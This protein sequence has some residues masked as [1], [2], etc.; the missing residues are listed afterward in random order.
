MIVLNSLKWKNFLSTGNQYNEIELDTSPMSIVVGKNGAGKSSIIDALTYGLFGKSFKKVNTNQ[1]INSVNERDMVV[2]VFF[3]V[4]KRKYHIKRGL[5]PRLFEIYCGGELIDQDA[6]ARDYQKYLE[7]SILKLNYKSFTQIVVLGSALFVPFM[8]LSSSDRRIIIEDIL[9][10][11]VFSVM[12]NLVKEKLSETNVANDSNKQDRNHKSSQIELHEKYINDMSLSQEAIINELKV[13]ASTLD[14]LIEN[15]QKEIKQHE[16]KIAELQFQ[17]KNGGL[18]SKARELDKLDIQIEST[19]QKAVASYSFLKHTKNCP[20]C[21]QDISEEFKKEKLIKKE[22]KIDE[23]KIALLDLTKEKQKIDKDVKFNEDIDQKVSKVNNQVIHLKSEINLHGQSKEDISSKIEDK[24]IKNQNL[25]EEKNLL[26]GLRAKLEELE[27]KRLDISEKLCYYGRINNLLQDGG[28]KTKIIKQY[29]PVINS[30]VNKYLKEMDF[31]VNFYLDENFN[32][33]IKS[34]YRDVFSYTSFSEGEK[35]RIDIALLLTWRDIA[36]MRNSVNVN[37]LIMDEIFDSSL[38]QN[39]IDDVLKLFNNLD[40]TNL[41]V[42]SH[43][44]DVLEDKFPSKIYVDKK[45]NF[46]TFER[47]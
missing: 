12:R 36:A 3:T 45:Q 18:Y 35:Q 28:I 5:K 33:T 19:L 2:E 23:Y 38:D 27:K 10:I 7:T 15:K 29:L 21:E 22:K 37:L 39:G 11:Q 46:S 31:F 24:T 13:E 34:R 17:M 42:V 8:Q 25:E 9:D 40:N 26:A 43:R 14:I 20:T 16:H 32:E 1:L 6:A 30:R 44:G 41:F 4:G 47:E